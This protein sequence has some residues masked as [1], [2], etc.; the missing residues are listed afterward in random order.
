MRYRL[1]GAH[2]NFEIRITPFNFTTGFLIRPMEKSTWLSNDA[3]D[4]KGPAAADK[5]R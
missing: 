4:I 3:T 5:A 1:V 2:L